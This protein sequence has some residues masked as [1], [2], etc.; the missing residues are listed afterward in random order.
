MPITVSPFLIK[1]LTNAA[2]MKPAAP[3]TINS[4]LM[5]LMKFPS[6]NIC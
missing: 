6:H 4:D 3:V 5:A 2:P 1:R